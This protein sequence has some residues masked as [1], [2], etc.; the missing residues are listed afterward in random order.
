MRASTVGHHAGQIRVE[1]RFESASRRASKMRYGAAA[2]FPKTGRVIVI[3]GGAGSVMNRKERRVAGKSGRSAPAL[4]GEAQILAAAVR[5]HQVGQLAEAESLYRRLLALAPG[6]GKA[7]HNLAILA[8]QTVRNDMAAEILRRLITLEPHN[9]DAQYHLALALDG[10]GRTSDAVAHYERA[11]MLKPDHA[12]AHMNLGNALVRQGRPSEAIARYDRVLALQPQSAMAHYN[13]ANVLAVQGRLDEAAERYRTAIRLKPDYAEAHNNLG[14]TFKDRGLLDDAEAEYRRAL[15]LKPDYAEAL[16]N[17]GIVMTARGSSAEA[18]EHYRHALRVRADFAEAHNNLGLVLSQQGHADEAAAHFQKAV[19]LDPNYIDAYLN[20]AR[21]LY[22]V[23]AVGHAIEIAARALRVKETPD[24]RN[25]FA[26]YVGA[27]RTSEEAEPY[28]DAIA[29]ALREGWARSGELERV[30]LLLIKRDAAVAAACARAAASPQDPLAP[31]DLAALAGDPLLESLMI[32]GRVSDRDMERLLTVARRTLLDAAVRPDAEASSAVLAFACALARQC[33]I[34]EYVFAVGS[35]EAANVEQLIASLGERL[36]AGTDSPGLWAAV[37]ASYRPL[38]TLPDAERLLDAPWPPVLAEVVAQ[39]VREPREEQAIRASLPALTPIDDE[40]SRLVREQYEENPYPRWI[41]PPAPVRAFRL[42]EYVR[43]KYP[44][45][46]LQPM[47]AAEHADILIAGCGT[48]A[49]A[50]ETFQRISGARVL[51]IDLSATSLA[52]AIRKTRMLGLPIE[53]AQADILKLAGIGRTFDVIEASGVLHHLADPWE[54]W[55]ILLSLLRPGGVMS[56]GLYSRLARAEINAARALIAARGYRPTADDIRRCRQDIFAL[57]EGAPGAT[58]SRAGDFYSMS[59]CRD[60][61]FHVQEH[62]HTLPEIAAFL[63]EHKLRFLGFDLDP[64]MLKLYAEA[65]PGDP[66]MTDLA[67]WH[68]FERQ[69]P[70]LFVSMY[71][72]AVQKSSEAVG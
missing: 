15:A 28:R 45:A 51:A 1:T 19:T 21:Q 12:E 17:L 36:R 72:F 64:R 27:L 10:L 42:R 22:A 6:H 54:G 66:T 49:H 35:E 37:V 32:A 71:Q 38:G 30:S 62:Q 52:Y 25:V 55:R 29:R 9:A 5:H 63:D 40:I 7:L 34:N 43:L 23:G 70:G 13:I 58:V 16:N 2:W 24:A 59:E 48:G 33:F 39:Q 41:A 8:L 44:L 61:L 11:T 14:N 67:R 57:A 18:I 65:N 31:E 68:E 47:R 53:Y 26:R 50:I 56:V 46:P 69:N 4:P 60:L 20:F 3:D